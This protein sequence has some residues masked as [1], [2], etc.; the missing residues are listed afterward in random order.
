MAGSTEEEPTMPTRRPSRRGRRI[1]TV[2]VAVC[3]VG[4]GIGAAV[5]VTGS[6]TGSSAP[7][8]AV[9]KLLEA[10]NHSDLLGAIDAVVPGERTAI[11]PGMVGL[12]A[13]LER[14]GVLSRSTD[15]SDIGGLSLHFA[16]IK[17]ATTMLSSTIAAVAITRGSV[18]GTF[19][20]AKLPVGSFVSTLTHGLLS[21]AKQT[22][23]SNV[24][25]GR[26]AIVTEQVNGTWYV[27]LGYT[28]AYD[29]LRSEHL[30]ASL[31]GTNEAVSA[32]GAST[33][34][35]AVATML[36][37]AAAF[38]LS[39][40]IGDLPSGEM[41]ALQS[42]APLF[43]GKAD[44][45]LTKARSEVALRITNLKLS[46]S[47]VAGGMLVKVS[48]LSFQATVEGITIGYKGG[49]LT[50]SYLGRSVRHCPNP[51]MTRAADAKI[52]AVLPKSL[53]GLATRLTKN[54]PTF[55]IVTVQENG[56]WFVSPVATMFDALNGSLSILQPQDLEAIASLAEDPAELHALGTSLEKVALGALASGSATF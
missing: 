13:Q 3:L 27:S 15:L 53:R 52:I 22:S 49:C 50:Y 1:V 54:P 51:A 17:T 42:Y 20:A 36:D 37:D 16:G 46:S 24:T 44:R 56:R 10:A 21:G 31:P 43:L 26:E 32:T 33:P 5:A 39:G 23:T 18:T 14:L 38:N 9:D 41:G 28:I 25:T 11:Q 29:A 4:G 6:S 34:D 7:A 47:P 55:G 45:E 35:G 48:G 12:A 30:P 8:S 19:D 2:V 40:M